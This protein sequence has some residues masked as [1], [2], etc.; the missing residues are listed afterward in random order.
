MSNHNNRLLGEPENLHINI[1]AH[2]IAFN[3]SFT[4][5]YWQNSTSYWN[6]WKQNNPFGGNPTT[7]ADGN[8]MRYGTYANGSYLEDDDDRGNVYL[9][10]GFVQLFRGYM[11]RNAAGPYNISPGIGM[12]K[13]YFWDDNMRCNALPLYPEK[14]DCDDS[15]GPPQYDFE[16]AQF[17]IF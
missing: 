2:M 13:H 7:L 11:F 10:G 1:H 3:E 5:Q 17:R 6:D 4:I 9:W 8:G 14:I 12:D 16:I 15:A